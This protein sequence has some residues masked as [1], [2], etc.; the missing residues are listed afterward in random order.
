MNNA[1]WLRLW[2]ARQERL[3]HALHTSYFRHLLGERLFHHHIWVIDKRAIAGGLSLGLFVAFTPTIPFQ[4]LLCATGAI[5][6]RVNLSAALAACWVTNPLTALPIYLCARRLGQ[7]VFEHSVIGSHTLEFF[8]LTNRAGKLME[9]SL[10]LWTGA[11]IFSILSACLGNV[12]CRCAWNLLRRLA[13]KPHA[14]G[15][16]PS[17]D[18]PV[19]SRSTSVSSPDTSCSCERE[20][21]AA[22][23]D[24]SAG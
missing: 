6:L 7:Y 10:Y 4:M 13:D 24:P 18:A 22:P 20:C 23:D 5:L 14:E 17:C 21:R 8:S 11:M 1:R 3:K 12:A 9:H 15:A 2:H 19:T 16:A